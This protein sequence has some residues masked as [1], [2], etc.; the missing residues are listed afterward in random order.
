MHYIIT[1]LCCLLVV[2]AC[3][4]LF[5]VLKVK[6]HFISKKTKNI[7]T[8]F[9][10]LLLLITLLFPADSFVLSFLPIEKQLDYY[11]TESIDC[12]VQGEKSAIGISFEEDTP[13]VT[14]VDKT[15]FLWR[16][17]F[18]NRGR[19]YYERT[20][21]NSV[22]P[23]YEYRIA[24]FSTLATME[25]YVAVSFVS[26][27]NFSVMTIDQADFVRIDHP[28][29]QFYACSYIACVGDTFDMQS[30]LINGEPVQ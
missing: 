6:G 2:I 9:T 25:K 30:L 22:F 28:A 18:T 15:L 3:S 10:L 19:Y 26:S 23:N 24:V 21:I 8:V 14:F 11:M 16:P 5:A 7:P 4:F 27:E 17:V 1:L 29:E 20:P 12:V 13:E